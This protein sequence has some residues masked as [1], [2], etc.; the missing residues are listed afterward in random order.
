MIHR[1]P[2]RIIVDGDCEGEILL[3]DRRISFYGEID[4]VSGIIRGLGESIKGRALVF[5]GGRGSTVGSYIIYG[6]KYYGNQPACII[7][8]EAEPIIIAGTVLAD[9][10]LFEAVDYDGLMGIISW[11]PGGFQV[12]HRRGEKHVEIQG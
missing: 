5:R 1:V 7:V 12:R 10:P 8:A 9:I 3:V 2:V 4:P 11:E 6:L